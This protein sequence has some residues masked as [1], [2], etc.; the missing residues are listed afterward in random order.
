MSTFKSIALTSLLLLAAKVQA[1]INI[2]VANVTLDIPL[3]SAYTVDFNLGGNTR[4][5]VY[6]DPFKISVP[7]ITGAGATP[8][9]KAIIASTALWFCMDPLQTIKYA[10]SGVSGDL[11]YQSTNPANFN[12]YTEATVAQINNGG[13]LNATEIADIGKLFA[14]NY[15]A[16]S[17]TTATGLLNAAALQIAIWEVVNES[18]N[19]SAAVSGY[20]LT[21]VSAGN[22]SITSGNAT[23]IATAQTMLTNIAS[24]LPLS[25]G[26]LDYLIDGTY[27]SYNSTTCTTTTVLVQDLVG[28]APPIP[29]SANFATGAFG[30]LGLA[31][32]AKLR[33]RKAK[34]STQSIA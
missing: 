24:A 15:V 19:A 1:Q 32:I 21:G 22:F 2:P 7:G 29:E 4:T 30:L 17:A 18:N 34:V 25:S 10:G 6:V 23:L 28:W 8:A 26:T 16:A 11:V 33:S 9:E 27:S 12:K 20:H 5:G 14:Q 31:V 3:G 13:G